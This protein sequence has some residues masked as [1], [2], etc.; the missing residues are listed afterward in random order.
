MSVS[1]VPALVSQ[2]VLCYVIAWSQVRFPVGCWLFLF[3]VCWTSQ[4]LI[5]IIVSQFHSNIYIYTSCDTCAS[6]GSPVLFIHFKP[7]F[8]RPLFNPVV[9]CNRGTCV[10]VLA[11]R[12]VMCGISH[13]LVLLSLFFTLVSCS[14]CIFKV[15]FTLVYVYL[16]VS[17]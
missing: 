12:Q 15:C 2:L 16:H 10:H 4:F 8:S 11:P 17:T 14:H 6:H 13:I 3:A 1:L 5:N 9:P 7:A